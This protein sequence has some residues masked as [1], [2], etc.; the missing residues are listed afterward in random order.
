MVSDRDQVLVLRYK[1]KMYAVDQ[2]RSLSHSV[3]AR[4]WATFVQ[5]CPHSSAP[6]SDGTVFDIE[7]FGLALSC[8]ITCP[9]HMWSFDLTT[10]LADRGNYKL[11]TWQ[12]QLRSASPEVPI[13]GGISEQEVS[14]G[15]EVQDEQEVWVRRRPRIG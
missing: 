2:V 12:V 3:D 15:Q 5:Q 4:I 8:A 6:L 1:G 14:M 7:D 10:G 11:K 13:S 9:K